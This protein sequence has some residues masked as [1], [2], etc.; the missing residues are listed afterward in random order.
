MFFLCCLLSLNSFSQT[1]YRIDNNFLKKVDGKF[2][3]FSY[4]DEEKERPY[5]LM[6]QLKYETKDSS[7]IIKNLT[8]LSKWGG[9]SYRGMLLTLKEV[10]TTFLIFEGKLQATYMDGDVQD[11][12]CELKF[13]LYSSDNK[14]ETWLYLPAGS[15]VWGNA[16]IGTQAT[17]KGIYNK[18][19]SK[20]P[21]SEK[22]AI[23]EL[24]DNASLIS[25]LHNKTFKSTNGTQVRIGMSSEYN[26]YGVMINGKTMFFNLTYSILTKYTAIVKGE[27]LVDNSLLKISV[28]TRTNSLINA[29]T[30]Y[31]L[32]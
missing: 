4:Y 29:G 7:F 21:V 12:D 14:F 18:N 3:A 9:T 1:T 27:S 19:I 13:Y 17:A 32:Q 16:T 5:G 31:S 15:T 6:F 22:Q 30:V 28:D 25:Y 20:Q 2:F 11:V 8:A 26:T 24:T 10:D 23:T